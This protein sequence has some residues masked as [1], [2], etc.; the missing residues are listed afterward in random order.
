MWPNFLNWGGSLVHQVS[1]IFGLSYKHRT[2]R[3]IDISDTWRTSTPNDFL[4]VSFKL[5]SACGVK[6]YLNVK[7]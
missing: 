2:F 6:I 4:K 1:A 3:P 7:V 5:Q